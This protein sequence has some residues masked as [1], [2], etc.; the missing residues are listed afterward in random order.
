MGQNVVTSD[1]EAWRRHRRI[2]APAFN[3][4]TYRNVWETTARVYADMLEQ[5]GWVHVDETAPANFNKITHK[6]RRNVSSKSLRN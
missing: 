1:G 2:T 5:E 4:T 6:V 3:H